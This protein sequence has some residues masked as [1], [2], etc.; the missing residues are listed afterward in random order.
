M[1]GPS[2]RTVVRVGS[3]RSNLALLQTEMAV[4]LLQKQNPHI[5]FEV[6]EMATVGDKILDVSLSKI[7]D[8]SLFTKEL[9]NALLSGEV[10]LVV[11]SLKDVPSILPSGLV[12]GCVFA[13]AS[14]DDVVLM[15][16]HYRGRKLS[17]LPIGSTIGTSAVRRVATLT[18]KYPHLKF[19]SIRGNLNTRL[20]KLDTPPASKDNCCL[21]NPSQSYDAIILAK[22]GVER[23]GWSHRIDQVLTDSFYAVSQG[24]LA[25]E[26]RQIDNFIMN[27][28]SGIHDESAA[29]T[30][31]AERSLM[32]QLDGGCSIPIGV[33][34]D[35]VLKG[36]LNY[37]QLTLHANILSVDG[38][39][40]VERS[41]SVVFPDKMPINDCVESSC[42]LVQKSSGYDDVSTNTPIIESRGTSPTSPTKDELKAALDAA[43]IFMGVLVTPSS[44]ISRLRMAIAQSLGCVVAQS[45]LLSG[46]DEILYEIRSQSSG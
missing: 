26:C 4:N 23:M 28:L 44:E 38:G 31:I 24:A 16:P 5:L 22:A 18:R 11:H 42:K 43:S 10:D 33:R 1:L 27:L 41:A 15:A 20:A 35:L 34:S 7:G 21:T 13:R 39:K 12:L 30:T 19:V 6:V 3:R 29:L 25:C 45:L 32:R 17:D 9:E 36:D 8:K 40:S 46:A 37:S 2:P 14:P